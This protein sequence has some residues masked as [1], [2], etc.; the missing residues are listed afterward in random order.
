MEIISLKLDEHMLHNID[1]SIRKHN[2]STRTEF[3]RAAIR[4]KLEE[5][6][7]DKL[8]NEFLKFRGKAKKKTT[9][10]ENRRTREKVSKGLMEELDKRFS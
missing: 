8:I 1:G 7:R 6:N 5:L 2:F 10:E 9:Y 4:D 3:I